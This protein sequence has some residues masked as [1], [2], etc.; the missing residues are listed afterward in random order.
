MTK[1]FPEFNY[2]PATIA[3]F[4]MD[5][6]L[7]TVF[8]ECE[9]GG[10]VL[11][12]ETAQKY[13]SSDAS[14]KLLSWENEKYKVEILLNRPELHPELLSALTDCQVFTWRVLAHQDIFSLSFWSRL[15]MN[16]PLEG[17]A[18]SGEYLEAQTWNDEKNRISLGTHDS[19]YLYQRAEKNDR[20]PNRFLEFGDQWNAL[21]FVSMLPDGLKVTLPNVKA[22]DEI[23]MH[24]VAAWSPF[25]EKNCHTW[26]A[27]G[28]L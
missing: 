23:Q 5:T 6:P 3:Q 11:S 26:L 7:G 17:G 14:Q 20:L 8:S 4:Q 22:G 21:N 15:L 18:D 27:V 2:L 10:T 24:F 25:D 12:V 1:L 13:A 19:A 28:C 9:I 16:K